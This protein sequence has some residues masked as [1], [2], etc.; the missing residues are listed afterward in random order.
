MQQIIIKIGTH[1]KVHIMYTEKLKT[2]T[3]EQRVERKI[4]KKTKTKKTNKP[5]ANKNK[6][7]NKTNLNFLDVF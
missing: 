5:K 3:I 7:T 6:Q 4:T 2:K 1:K